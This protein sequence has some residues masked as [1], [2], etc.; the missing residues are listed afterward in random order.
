M[1]RTVDIAPRTIFLILGVLV[2][3]W[4][5][6]HIRDILYL[7]FISFIFATAIRPSVE[8]LT[9]YRI[10]RVLAILFVYIA[11]I[12]FIVAFFGS[13]I[14]QFVAQGTLLI[15]RIPRIAETI[16]PSLNIDQG[17][18]TSQLAPITR[19]IFEFSVRFV[20]NIITFITI[21]VFSFYFLLGRNHLA[22][23]IYQW[24]PKHMAE[25]IT[26]IIQ[27]L[28][29]K[30][31]AWARGQALL[32]II[33]G[34]VTYIG[35]SFLRVDYALPLAVLAGILEILPIVGPLLSA[36]PA[37]LIAFTVSPLLALSV[38]AL[39]FIIQQ[40]ENHLIVPQVMKRSVG[41]SPVVVIIAFMIGSRF[42]GV[43]GAFLA[44]PIVVTGQII[45]EHVLS[46]K[47]VSQ[48]AT[49]TS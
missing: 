37:I 14:P 6:L 29:E 16:L 27:K 40:L 26:V 19:N 4:I 33:I 13:F 48:S 21:F 49:K 3:V 8:W 12:G 44:V 47:Q 7:L 15:Q 31:G 41:L 25:D 32:M 10:P 36:I 11:L 17:F 9:N 18:L 34:V 28:E 23:T 46:K 1:H 22:L 20:N 30:L 43:M 35:L 42:E 24:V 45:I 2:G 38:A 5:V 39:Y